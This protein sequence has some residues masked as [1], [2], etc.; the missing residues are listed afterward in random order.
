MIIII[1][2]IIIIV[3]IFETSAFQNKDGRAY[4][5]CSVVWFWNVTLNAQYELEAL[6]TSRSGRCFHTK[7]KYICSWRHRSSLVRQMCRVLIAWCGSVKMV[8]YMGEWELNHIGVETSVRMRGNGNAQKAGH[9]DSIILNSTT[10]I[11]W[12]NLKE[13]FF[14]RPFKFVVR[15]GWRYW[16]CKLTGSHCCH[17]SSTDVVEYEIWMLFFVTKFHKICQLVSRVLIQV[18]E[19]GGG[20]RTGTLG[21]C[22]AY[23]RR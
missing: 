13:S 12:H 4:S 19:F 17:V 15:I 3:I 1:I 20:G 5:L 18:V 21:S 8:S 23:R 16:F 14:P 22:R 11:M 10:R 7:E 6:E 9:L 2:I